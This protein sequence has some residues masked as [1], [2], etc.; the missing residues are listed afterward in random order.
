MGKTQATT[1]RLRDGQDPKLSSR[2]SNRNKYP[3]DDDDDDDADYV[4]YPPWDDLGQYIAE[5]DSD[6]FSV[7]ASSVAVS[8]DGRTIAEGHDLYDLEKEDWLGYRVNVYT[9][10]NKL[11]QWV[12]VGSSITSWT[13]ELPNDDD[14]D[15]STAPWK[16]CE[17]KDLAMS[18]DADFLAIK[19]CFTKDDVVRQ[20]IDCRCQLEV[21]KLDYVDIPGRSEPFWS[22]V[23]TLSPSLDT[24]YNDEFFS[25]ALDLFVSSMVRVTRRHQTVRNFLFQLNV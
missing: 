2:G 3:D 15:T 12:A 6:A 8:S 13:S 24:Y 21:W 1:V 19:L 23:G 18:K 11:R 7:L 14:D 9:Y 5:A 16:L 17:Q 10:V 22:L 4:E 20:C 25:F